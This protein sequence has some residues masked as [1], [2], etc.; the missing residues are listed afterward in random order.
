MM[1]GSI[2]N[3]DPIRPG[4]NP[5]RA[6]VWSIVM[7][8]LVYTITNPF[9]IYNAIFRRE[10]LR[11]NLGNSAAMYDMSLDGLWRAI[12]ILAGAM[13]WFGLAVSTVA[14]SS[15]LPGSLWRLD[16]IR[17]PN[18]KLNP[19]PNPNPNSNGHGNR[20]LPSISTSIL[21]LLASTA[22]PMLLMFVLLAAGKPMEFAR[23]GLTVC[24][25]MVVLVASVADHLLRF[26]PSCRRLGIACISLLL[27]IGPLNRFRLDIRSPESRDVNLADKL[28]S[29]SPLVVGLHYEPAPWSAPPVD[30]FRHK[31]VLLPRSEN[32]EAEIESDRSDVN[33]NVD[34]D[35]VIH[36]IN[37]SSQ[38]GVD[39]RAERASWRDAEFSVRFRND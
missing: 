2:A 37:L 33:V 11:S 25:A 29:E 1:S 14:A 19:S 15:L 13:T 38:I 36:P 10:L 6:T 27:L 23:F 4:M 20:K 32:K 16:R 12:E 5:W 21:I 7:A 30:L 26:D 24:A 22:I 28:A 9:V 8:L 3:A 34:V 18:L 39:D 35:V 17:S 31:L